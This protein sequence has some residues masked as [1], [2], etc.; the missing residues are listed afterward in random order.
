MLLQL[1]LVSGMHT[2]LWEIVY[3]LLLVTGLNRQL[4]ISD[5]W[6][7][8]GDTLVLTVLSQVTP[9]ASITFMVV[10]HHF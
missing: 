7:A 8:M 9:L 4:G 5:E 1:F 10:V 3:Q 6:F 2:Y